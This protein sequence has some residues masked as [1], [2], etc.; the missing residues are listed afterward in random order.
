ME[1]GSRV[2]KRKQ[3]YVPLKSLNLQEYL[4]YKKAKLAQ[5]KPVVLD[6]PQRFRDDKE[7]EEDE[8][9]VNVSSSERLEP[10]N[11]K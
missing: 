5:V 3:G 6:N 7:S 8:A 9:N 2:E 11:P 1:F 4:D 10:K